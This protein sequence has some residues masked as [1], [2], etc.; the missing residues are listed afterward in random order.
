MTHAIA[1]LNSTDE[2]TKAAKLPSIIF[3]LLVPSK[4]LQVC[5]K[6]IGNYVSH[7]KAWLVIATTKGGI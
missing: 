5:T 2:N 7:S 4:S 1:S 3:I 6:G